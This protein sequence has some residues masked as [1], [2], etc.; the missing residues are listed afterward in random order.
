MRTTIAAIGALVL[1]SADNDEQ[2][3]GEEAGNSDTESSSTMT[4]CTSSN[5]NNENIASLKRTL[6][7]EEIG[8]LQAQL[9]TLQ[10]DCE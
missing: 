4:T 8:Q 7:E 5:S 2:G 9:K 3:Q 6:H 1:V 10:D